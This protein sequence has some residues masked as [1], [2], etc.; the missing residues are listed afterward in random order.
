MFYRINQHTF[1][2]IL[3]IL[4][5]VLSYFVGQRTA[6]VGSDTGSYLKFYELVSIGGS[7]RISDWLFF[8][9][10]YVL[11]HFSFTGG[12][13]LF[14][15]SIISNILILSFALK[16]MALRRYEAQRNVFLMI[17]FGVTL[18]SP[19]YWNT[20]LN[21][22]RTGVSIPFIYL[23]Y[24]YFSFNNKAIGLVFLSM[25]IGFHV[26]SV[27]FVFPMLLVFL[28]TKLLAGV[29][30]FLSVVYLSSLG[31]EVVKVIVQNFTFLGGYYDKF[32]EGTSSYSV[33]VRF[34]F[35]TFT[36]FFWG[37]LYFN[38]KDEVLVFLFKLYSILLI[39][40]LLFGFIAYS[41]RL[42]V[43]CWGLIPFILS[44]LTIEKFKSR[45]IW[46][47]LCVLLIPVFLCIIY[48]FYEEVL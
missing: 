35:F 30:L 9:V 43:Y 23:G 5:F 27:L 46:L 1:V 47:M 33:G 31:V 17:L 29:I 15:V 24:Y 39:P 36:M 14:L 4:L 3:L 22:I 19:F 38:Q 40:F 34:D 48:V 28:R 37:L 16:I 32:F 12:S 6:E 13:F 8:G 41:D 25:A 2:L 42:L 26:S 11:G 10:A 21:I 7:T 45:D 18:I 20:Q 44:Y